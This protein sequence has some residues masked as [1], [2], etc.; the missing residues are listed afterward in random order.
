MPRFLSLLFLST[1]ITFNA[2]AQE[3]FQPGYVVA[4]SND[5]LRG[6]IDDRN[7]DASPD[8]IY[9]R[10]N[11]GKP[12]AYTPTSITAFSVSNENYLGAVVKVEVSPVKMDYLESNATINTVSD[13]LFIRVETQGSRSLYSAMRDSKLNLYVA[14]GNQ[15]Q[16]L[17]FKKYKR[18][19][20]NGSVVSENKEYLGQL[21]VYLKECETTQENLKFVSYTR[22]SILK[23]FDQ[24]Y[25]CTGS[26]RTYQKT[27]DKVSIRKGILA[28]ATLTSINFG[29]DNDFPYL[30]DGDF[31]GSLN[32]TAGI[33]LDLVL[34][35][36]QG[37]WSVNN[38]LLFTTYK[39]EGTYQN[40]T[41]ENQYE[42]TTS[43]I[44]MSHLTL[45]TMLRFNRNMGVFD[46]FANVGLTNGIS[47][48]ET[49]QRVIF[50][51]L[52]ASEVYEDD[53]VVNDM[54]KYEQG[55][56][57]G[58]GGRKNNLI[59]EL[60]L[61]KG[62]GFTEYATLKTPTIRFFLTVGYRF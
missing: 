54:R 59:A 47:I 10:T 60:R 4:L 61:Q 33:F 55:F 48:G 9:F 37:R 34:P 1:L 35:R 19:T 13:T 24:F 56:L 11:A 8:I 53:L 45:H 41:S 27:K 12:V 5:T 58:L 28:G 30:A 40:Y 23:L 31:N 20:I 62:N 25:K 7:W 3:N 57:V 2:L 15:Y 51:K 36:N 39:L 44:G 22:T 6:F 49:N 50:R 32:P 21:A 18:E 16:L 26:G 29:S 17:R 14:D 46:F 38:E 52:F 42:I 43:T